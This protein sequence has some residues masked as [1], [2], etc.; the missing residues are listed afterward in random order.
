[1]NTS[2][3]YA[4]EW[5]GVCWAGAPRRGL[6]GV[7]GVWVVDSRPRGSQG[8]KVRG[9]PSRALSSANMESKLPILAASGQQSRSYPRLLPVEQRPPKPRCHAPPPCP[10][11]S[12]AQAQGLL[13]LRQWVPSECLAGGDRELACAYDGVQAEVSP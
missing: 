3:V 10:F 1:M 12:L 5:Q 6:E 9:S 11:Q 8:G 13:S 2:D 4:W 7:Q